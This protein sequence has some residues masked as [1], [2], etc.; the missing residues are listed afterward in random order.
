MGKNPSK[1]NRSR[2]ARVLDRSEG[3]A[4][5]TGSAGHARDRHAGPVLDAGPSIDAYLI[6]RCAGRTNRA[7][8]FLNQRDQDAAVA[9][10]LAASDASVADGVNASSRKTVVA[11]VSG[12]LKDLTVRVAEK[13]AG[14]AIECY[15]AKLRE[16]TV[17][18]DGDFQIVTAYPSKFFRTS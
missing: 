9:H 16:V 11:P 13:D 18:Y 15:D 17:V 12:R 14:G 4:T 5:A 1:F 7:S 6:A 2:A 8:A 10:A 3:Q